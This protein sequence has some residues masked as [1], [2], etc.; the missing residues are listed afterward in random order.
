MNGTNLKFQLKSNTRNNT[1]DSINKEKNLKR[2][3]NSYRINRTKRGILER[4][5]IFLLW[6]TPSLG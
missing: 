3:K 4:K 5:E 1:E 2:G 6:W